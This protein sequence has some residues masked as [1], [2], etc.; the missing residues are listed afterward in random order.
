MAFLLTGQTDSGKSTIAGHLLYKV[1]YF[2]TLTDEDKK[3]YRKHL[4]N[5]ITSTSKSKYSIL[6]DLIDGEILTNKTKTQEFAVCEFDHKDVHFILVDTPGHQLYICNL[7]SALFHVPKLTV[8][9]LVLSSQSA[10]FWEAWEKGTSKENLLLGRSVGCQHV[11]LLWNK[12]DLGQPGNVE[13]NTVMAFCKSL[14]F[15]TIIVRHVS[16]YTGDGL[17]EVL[18]DVAKCALGSNA[19]CTTTLRSNVSC[20][21][22]LVNGMF[23]MTPEMKKQNVLVSRGFQCVLH[24]ASG[25]YDV[26]LEKL[27]DDRDKP[28]L[29]VRDNHSVKMMWVLGKPIWC[30]SGDRVIFRHLH[31]TLGFGVVSL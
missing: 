20:K 25:E 22:I 7:L 14:K 31:M 28:V 21:Q 6:M 3:L 19:L 24:H 30:S 26:E 1:G 8:L 23:F 13:M 10:E 15:K 27:L 11:I 2:D 17:L 4:E 12:T 5:L 29:I 9:C 16:G 18:N